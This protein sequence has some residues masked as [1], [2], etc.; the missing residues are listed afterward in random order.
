MV[1][2]R[3]VLVCSANRG[4]AGRRRSRVGSAR[5]VSIAFP[6]V[7]SWRTRPPLWRHVNMARQAHPEWCG[8]SMRYGRSG[9]TV[10]EYGADKAPYLA[11]LSN[12]DLKTNSSPRGAPVLIPSGILSC[13]SAAILRVALHHPRPPV[14]REGHPRRIGPVGR[15]PGGT[16]QTRQ[17]HLV[18]ELRHD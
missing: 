6:Q 18:R 1:R 3:R 11:E 12:S 2:V 13:R 5:A 8:Q 7:T 15:G 4:R 14:S 16:Q 17:L 9:G 10:V